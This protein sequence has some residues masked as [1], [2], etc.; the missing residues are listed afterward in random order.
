MRVLFLSPYLPFPVRDGGQVRAYGLL[1]GLSGFA[2]VRVLSIGDVRHPDVALA[3]ET[4]G[5]LGIELSVHPATGPAPGDGAA[6]N[7]ARP[8]DAAAHFRSPDLARELAE[9]IGTW[10]PDVL[11]VEELV[12]AQYLHG[13]TVPRVLDRQK[14][15]P[16]YHR[17]LAD[18]GFGD[19][20]W[21]RRE[22][23]RFVWW[24][25]QL[26]RR[27]DRVLTVGREDAERLGEVWA[28][29]RVSAVPNGVEDVI[30]RPA[31]RTRDVHHVLLYGTA[32]Y[33]PNRL[34][35]DDY[36]RDVWPRLR[37]AA[38]D[39]TTRVV[40]AGPPGGAPA[41][42]PRVERL[43]FVEDVARV[44]HG[45]G[46]LV[47]LLRV[48]GGA[49]NQVLEALAAG[50][51][52][53]S[54]RV[55]VEG[56]AVAPGQHYLRADTAAEIV[57]A[58][59]SL[60][61][62]PDRA[63]RLSRRGAAYVD[64]AHRW[65]I[66]GRQLEALY[67]DLTRVSPRGPSAR[68]VLLFGVGPLPSDEEATELSFPGHRT[69]HFLAALQAARCD[70][71]VVLLE[72]PGGA[73]GSRGSI[74]RLDID[75]YL[76]GR[77]AQRL[78]DASP[79][80]VVV[81][82][83]GYHAARAASQLATRA[84]RFIDLAGDLAAE[85]QLRHDSAGALQD[86]LAVL[87]Q[88]LSVGDRFSVVGLSQRLAVLG[89]LGLIGRLPGTATGRD[90]VDIVP[91]AC[92][93]PDQAPPL[94]PAGFQVLGLGGYNTWMDE[95][96]LFDA[97]VAAMGKE[98]GL[99]FVSLGGPVPGHET[100]RHARF[101]ER[102]STSGLDARFQ[103]LGRRSRREARRVLEQSH[104]VIC[105]SRPCLEAEL[106]SRQR[107]VEAMA[108][109]RAVVTT[110]LGDLAREIEDRRAGVC[111]PPGDPRAASEALLRLAQDRQR[112]EGCARAG[113]LLWE[114]RFRPD[115]AYPALLRFVE[116]P[117]RWPP[118]VLEDPAGPAAERLRL[119]GELAAI[120]GS[121]TFRM[122]RR[123]DRWL[124]RG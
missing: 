62:D 20:A 93:G 39:L 16:T 34:A 6:E 32:G 67:R 71:E 107:L 97:L 42:D 58:V 3:R 124:G 88:A 91:V 43:G 95:D 100:G 31:D 96:T 84:P 44:L 72:A 77:P 120:R 61:R 106:G 49:H 118:S 37:R 103:D 105:L 30:R 19:E 50:M 10:H 21:H 64:S 38:P 24:E 59:L 66:V 83:G 121:L 27:V 9:Q 33:P 25:S 94:P 87:R 28:H 110:R 2:E 11:H 115:V 74:H 63:E 18:A 46:V 99:R 60:R 89:Q 51:P 75:A 14:L 5:A 47:A 57:D 78:H 7:L 70:V 76:G 104:V 45:P 22:A 113:R 69:A 122:L 112:L 111:V 29:Q 119:Q 54:S 79:P 123:L 56:L 26:L 4:L 55:G 90:P 117:E 17:A 108:F 53:V 36:F 98:P 68:R 81:S 41:D 13:H 101:W 52:V 48:G 1:R 85:G 92:A 23:A 86:H 82:A 102:V 40:G 80:D 12:M 116:A 35:R 8:P 15:E 65:D 73:S 114:E 109:E